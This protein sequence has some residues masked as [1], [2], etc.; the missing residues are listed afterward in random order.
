MRII[1][2]V[3]DMNMGGVTTIVRN[4]DEGLKEYNVTSKIV[5]LK[6][7]VDVESLYMNSKFSILKALISF[8][9]I[10]KSFKPDIIH[11]HTVFSHIIAL[12]YKFF[13]NKSV[14]V[15]CTEHGSFEIKNKNKFVFILFRLL[16]NI[17]NKIV[18]VS[19]FSLF[20]YVSNNIVN[21][22]NSIVIYNGIKI[23]DMDMVVKNKYQINKEINLCYIGRFSPEKN[24]NLLLESYR[25]LIKENNNLINLT[26]I[27]DGEQKEQLKEYC[28]QNNLDKIKFLGFRS[29]VQD[30]LKTMDC[31][32]LSSFTE[33]LPTVVL[34]AYSQRVFVVSTNCGGVKEIIKNED[35]ISKDFKAETLADRMKYVINLCEVEKEK[36]KN[37]NFRLLNDKFSLENMVLNYINLYKDI[38]QRK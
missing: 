8:N 2:L 7:E 36:N 16:S 26:L 27:G 5:S 11:S 25:I 35:F 3:P 24:L 22:F 31:L 15:V 23:Y 38:S 29:D 21:K 20:S 28:S 1:M 9:K 17:S 33:G 19:K 37:Y 30:I 12:L 6:K 4:L 13:F 10:S 34:E 14:K 18:F 32:V